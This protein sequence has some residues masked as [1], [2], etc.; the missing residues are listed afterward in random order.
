MLLAQH[1]FAG[2]TA[3]AQQS[4]LPP[5]TAA[6]AAP[7]PGTDLP[8][9]HPVAPGLPATVEATWVPWPLVSPKPGS[10]RTSATPHWL[11]GAPQTK[12]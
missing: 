6:A 4:P 12:S 5:S 3:L 7:S 10:S 1:T 8:V 9:Y 2:A 11:P